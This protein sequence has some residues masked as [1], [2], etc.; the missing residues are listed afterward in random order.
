M[1]KAKTPTCLRA[2]IA[3]QDIVDAMSEIPGYLD[4]TPGDFKEVYLKA[5]EH[6]VR[7]LTRSLQVH[8]VM[9]RQVVSVRAQTPLRLTAELMA[10]NRVSGVPV[11]SDDGTVAGVVSEKDFLVHMGAG[12]AGTF[13]EVVAECLKGGGCVAAPIR[14]ATAGDIMTSPAITIPETASVAETAALF[15]ERSINRAPVVDGN[16]VMTGI[17]SRDD[18]L[19]PTGIGGTE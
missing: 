6:A 2:D 10:K 7:R 19:F 15:N 13:M 1:V 5:Y 17:I 3:D 16:G 14:A 4:I 9:T 12:T 8:E 18:I 11:I